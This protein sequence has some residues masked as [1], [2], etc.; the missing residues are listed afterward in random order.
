[1]LQK[2]SLAFMSL[3]SDLLIKVVDQNWKTLQT[4]DLCDCEGLDYAIQHTVT[5]CTELTEVCFANWDEHYSEDSIDFLANNLTS[6]I[7]K[8]S[9]AGQKFVRDKNVE[10]LVCR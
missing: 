8:L 9:L 4:L 10:S 3:N 1:M 2:L 5:H 7:E 6:K